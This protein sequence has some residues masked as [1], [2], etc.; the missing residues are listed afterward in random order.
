MEYNISN[1][2]EY[3]KKSKS[4]NE[5]L[6]SITDIQIEKLFAKCNLFELDAIYVMLANSCDTD[7]DIK[8]T[9]DIEYAK[10]G[11]KNRQSANFDVVQI[12]QGIYKLLNNYSKF[13][14]VE[15]KFLEFLVFDSL[16][17]MSGGRDEQ[18]VCVSNILKYLNILRTQFTEIIEYK[19]KTKTLTKS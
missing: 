14:L 1:K 15:L 2:L 16:M 12:E 9:I 5:Y 11:F 3:L 13:N 17:Y 18:D 7:L 4:E 10:R 6:S 19:E 8:K